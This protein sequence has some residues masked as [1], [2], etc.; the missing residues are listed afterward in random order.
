MCGY[1]GLPS[2]TVSASRGRFRFEGATIDTGK[3]DPACQRA[4]MVDPYHDFIHATLE[5]Y[6][7]L[8]ATRLHGWF[9]N[10]DT[11]GRPGP[12]LRRPHATGLCHF[13]DGSLSAQPQACTVSSQ[14]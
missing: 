10:A 11:T 5:Q 3:D 9:A 12:L 2:R 1:S 4:E 14:S 6:P 8:R 13:G 7:R